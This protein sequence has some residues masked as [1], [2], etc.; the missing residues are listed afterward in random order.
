MADNRD[1]RLMDEDPTE[2]GNAQQ[3]EPAA[4]RRSVGRPPR[5]AAA[6][7]DERIAAERETQDREF[8]EDRELTD[9]ERVEMFRDARFQA[10]L[11]DLPVY[12]GHHVCWL[13]TNNR[14][15]SIPQ[16]LRLGYQLIRLD[17]CPSWES[18]G[19]T[20]GKVEN[21]V[22]I[23]EMVAARIPLSL[24]NRY[25]AI[26]HYEEPLD[27]ERKLVKMTEAMQAQAEEMGLSLEPANGME[28]LK[29]RAPRPSAF[30]E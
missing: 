1:E 26:R 14:G 22:S 6:H 4:R 3:G 8:S 21:V 17:Q 28:A 29:A 18:A 15:D 13:T 2:G 9:A 12:S 5:S 23:N 11:P 25:M 7:H 10:I 30:T 24:Y 27:E 16:R 20:V 19:A